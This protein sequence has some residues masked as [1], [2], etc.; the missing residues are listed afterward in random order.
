MSVFRQ[1]LLAPA[2]FTVAA[3]IVAFSSTA[4]AQ[5]AFKVLH[6][7]VAGGPIRPYGSVIQ[8]SD[9]S[10]YGATYYGGAYD[11]GTIYKE[12]AGSITVL[13]DFSGT[14]NDGASP[15]SAPIQAADGNFY[16]TTGGGGALGNGAAYKITP[17]GT[18][19][20]LH[21]FN[22][23]SGE[24]Y[25]PYA[26]LVQATDGNFYGT[27]SFGNGTTSFGT[28]YK[29]TP[30]GTVTV[31]H[32]FAGGTA[33]GAYPY[34][35]LIQATDGNFYGTTSQGGT[36]TYGT[37]FKITPAGTVT[38]LHS[39]AGG[40][41]D[42]YSP[43]AALIQATD[44]NLYGTTYGGGTGTSYYG[45]VY[46]ITLDGTFTL[47]RAFNYTSGGY[48]YAPLVQAADGNLY[49][50]TGYGGASGLG[51]AFKITLGGVFSLLHS[52]SGSAD[53]SHLYYG[54]LI[55][56]TDGNFYG[57]TYDGGASNAGEMFQMTPAG[58]VTVQYAFSGSAD[59]RSAYYTGLIQASDGNFYGTSSRGGT[60]D[61]GTAFKMTPAGVV[62]VL[63]SFTYG[64][65]GGYPYAPLIQATDGNFYGTTAFGGTSGYGVVFKMTPA[66]TVTS[67]HSFNYSTDGGYPY[68]ALI[69]GT[70]G[71]FY[72][73]TS[74]G[75][76]SSNGTVFKMTSA[77][78]VTVLHSF[79]GGTSDGTA[80]RAAL[81]QATDGNLYG[82]TYQG[83]A[84]N[85]GT[86]FKIANS[87][88]SPFS[89][90]HSFT[91][92]TTDGSGP[93]AALIQAT[94]GNLHGTTIS[95]GSSS[96]GTAFKITPGG[97]FTLLH[98][99]VYASDGGYPYTPL[100]QA[101]DGNFY[102]TASGG[103]ASSGGTLFKM[104]AAGTV[105]VQRAFSSNSYD[106]NGS[107]L[108]N[109]IV[110]AADSKFY[111][112]TNQGGSPG[113]GVVFRFKAITQSF[114]DDPL[115]AGASVIK[116]AHFTE[117]RTRAN[118]VRASCGLA[119]YGWTDS[120]T[121][122][123]TVNTVDIT[124][125]R[126]ALSQAYSACGLTPPT[127]STD[128]TLSIGTPIRAAHISEFRTAL[129]AIE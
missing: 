48:S 101:T 72:G 53:G 42:G 31:L 8:G 102:G 23:S 60:A 111:G 70:D 86:V 100:I 61:Y 123:A 1:R 47:L 127:Y 51:T 35:A 82:T 97:T 34:A 14:S 4:S 40:T 43:Y 41:G 73:T 12:T 44:G 62:T 46:R 105:T 33:D 89:I 83:G 75:G 113:R 119:A 13:H 17:S 3:G 109:R 11:R 126:T 120:V 19:T 96:N 112:I 18:F 5:S 69:Q 106:T 30:A 28:V 74:Q 26:A 16:G 114:T 45:T 87:L 124:D 37:V 29:M 80:P 6:T 52:F 93:W 58:A 125:L 128:P 22:G 108:Y 7:F 129:V 68:G 50:T 56:A 115:T 2:V 98:A 67:L 9:G 88:G 15:Y 27:T 84:S 104:T 79:A 117:L 24:W 66:G 64:N 90:L 118:Y 36:S 10:F 122:G 39:F 32:V 20:L 65:D 76:A 38:V 54:A 21:S 110:Q 95:G 63:Y 25:T 55:Q 91:G 121:V 85:F 81:L 49:G 94:D 99:F 92:G 103:G 59:A 71:N 77:G 57:T 107:Y 116:A 78:A